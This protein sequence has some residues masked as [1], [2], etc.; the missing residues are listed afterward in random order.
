MYAQIMPTQLTC[1]NSYTKQP[2]GGETSRLQSDYNK[3]IY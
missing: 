1:C 2:C 3:N